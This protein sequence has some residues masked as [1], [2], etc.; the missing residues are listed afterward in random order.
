[1][2]DR[3]FDTLQ[4]AVDVLS[5]TLNGP[6]T[7]ED[8]EHRLLAYSK[9]SHETDSAR[10]ETIM[11]RQVPDRV[12]EGLWSSGLLQKLNQTDEPIRIPG[13]PAVGLG[14]R[15]AISIRQQQFVL[16]Y[17]WVLELEEP[18]TDEQLNDLKDMV[19]LIRAMLI[20]QQETR[21]RRR[22]ERE[23]R[24]RHL[25][26]GTETV[27]EVKRRF[28]AEGEPLPERGVVVQFFC[29]R[30]IKEEH[31]QALSF[32]SEKVKSRI[33]VTFA[34]LI[35]GKW[36][37]YLT[38]SLKKPL[39]EQVVKHFIDQWIR[40][41]NDQF[42]YANVLAGVGQHCSQLTDVSESFHQ[43]EKVIELK[44][45]FAYELDKVYYFHELG[46]YRIIVDS[47]PIL[48][49]ETVQTLA[50]YDQ[51]QGTELL[52][53]LEAFLDVDERNQAAAALLH[54]H[55]NTLNYRMKRIYELTGL[56]VKN[57][58]DKVSLYLELK[59]RRWRNRVE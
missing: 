50:A 8:R 18:L 11:N 28:Q 20:K 21:F 34:M 37:V 56:D 54:V 10:I 43:A 29:E 16:G 46:F 40:S 31:E 12:I 44:G 45:E 1:M 59:L 9:H 17:I 51:K 26:Q 4:E 52:Q 53:T 27:A 55:P 41:W 5:L 13:I 32:I 35:D 39:D 36:T 48:E 2:K 14:N 57:M 24:W 15:V 19:S 6:V 49:S 22:L 38:D 23:E 25:Y 42:S 33:L 3:S 47:V 7:L 30:T 58:K